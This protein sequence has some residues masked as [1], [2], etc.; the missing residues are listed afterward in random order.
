MRKCLALF[1]SLL[2]LF[3]NVTWPASAE[4]AP[5]YSLDAADQFCYLWNNSF[6]RNGIDMYLGITRAD[7]NIHIKRFTISYNDQVKN[8][9]FKSGLVPSSAW[10][11]FI[12][13]PMVHQYWFTV[14]SSKG[15]LP[16]D[17]EKVVIYTDDN[18][19]NNQSVMSS[20]E[21]NDMWSVGIN[22]DDLVDILNCDQ[23]T[24]KLTFDGKN[25]VIDISQDEYYYIYDMLFAL[26]RAQLY[27]DT[28]FD[29]YYSAEFLPGGIRPTPTP[30]VQVQNAYSF[31]SD[32]DAI[33]QAAK[34][35]FYVEIY[36]KNYDYI[37]NA[38]GF[39][40]FDEHLFVT[41]QHVINNASFLKIWDEDNNVYVLDKVIASDKNKDIAILLF[42][43]GE[44]YM[45]L[46]MNSEETLKRGQPVVT[47][48]SPKGFQGTVAEGII[49]AFAELDEYPDV[50]LIQFTASISHG[51]S[52]GCLFDDNGKV[53]GI[54][55]AGIDDGQNINFA[56][57]IK[58]V[59]ELYN[60]WDKSSF[61]PLGT[62]RS[63]NMVGITPTPSLTPS[64]TPIP[65]TDPSDEIQQDQLEIQSSRIGP[66]LEC[67]GELPGGYVLDQP[68]EI[69]VHLDVRNSGDD[70][71]PGP[72]ELYY[73][74]LTQVE[75]FG[76]P[77]LK[78]GEKRSWD[79][80]WKVTQAQLDDGSF[81]FYVRYPVKDEKSGEISIKAKKLSFKIDKNPISKVFLDTK[82]Y[83]K[84]FDVSLEGVSFEGNKLIL[85][86]TISP[87][88][89]TM[90][91]NKQSSADLLVKYSIDVYDSKESITPI[92]HKDYSVGLKKQD[93]YSRSAN[94]EIYLPSFDFPTV[95]WDYEVVGFE[96]IVYVGE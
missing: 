23:I 69:D 24:V 45:P 29:R 4:E 6:S 37:G 93:G 20:H 9:D 64:P 53:I 8:A 28:T 72:V 31:R 39:V 95:Y 30:E 70:A 62:N 41:N 54:T 52:G 44:K 55:S 43:D 56:V 74:D 48:G 59:I 42:P 75:E 63:W 67:A 13:D 91:K 38:S 89:A 73:P 14:F 79:G 94:I 27:S 40:S 83:E 21:P 71:F 12:Y 51:S 46:E 85:K 57:P 61:E 49:S 18:V 10:L 50:K 32:Y 35:L 16:S 77:T 87:K 5:I 86:Y 65:T 47:I 84:F 76:E 19:Y 58:H 81:A 11:Y 78:P 80:K 2:I 26:I 34:S 17:L 96:G 25:E 1:L 3:T 68:K 36:D 7:D 92:Q 60:G 88:D 90:A 66:L 15:D 22:G 33:D 82:N